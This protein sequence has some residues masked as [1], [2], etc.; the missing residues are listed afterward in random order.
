VA[1]LPDDV[2]GIA[3]AVGDSAIKSAEKEA[4]KINA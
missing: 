2:K 3:K 1:G 4:A